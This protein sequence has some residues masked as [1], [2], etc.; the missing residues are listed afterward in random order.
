MVASA[1]H[2]P[3]QESLRQ[4]CAILTTYG[5]EV[6]NS[7][8]GT[9]RVYRGKSNKECC[10]IAAR[11]CDLFLGIVLP[12]YGSGIV[13]PRSITHEEFRAA[14][15]ANK[16]RWFLVHRDVVCARLMLKP[17]L[18]NEDG[19]RI[20]FEL[21]KNPILS[22][23]RV[24]DLYHDAL[25]NDIPVENRT[26]HWVQEFYRLPDALPF[27]ATQFKN[28]DDVRKD[29]SRTMKTRSKKN[30]IKAKKADTKP[31]KKKTKTTRTKKAKK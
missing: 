7:D 5:Y 27:L 25:Q 2:G 30:K 24:I 18:F 12:S 4:I 26:S 21:K 23:L 19:S 20:N 9:I 31:T 10:V 6:W 22:D 17:Y 15:A 16:P 11:E 28:V 3:F 29:I 1:I 13:G 8:R 14:I